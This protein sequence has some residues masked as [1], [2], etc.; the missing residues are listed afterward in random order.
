M[1]R[2]ARFNAL[3]LA[4][5]L[6]LAGT[7]AFAS[8]PELESEPEVLVLDDIVVAEALPD[9]EQ[10]LVLP[11]GRDIAIP[12]PGMEV[13]VH[14]AT[15]EGAPEIP[16]TLVTAS[17][18][19]EIGVKIGEETFGSPEG[20]A[21]LEQVDEALSVPDASLEEAEPPLQM[22]SRA[23]VAPVKCTTWDNAV[24]GYNWANRLVTWNYNPS[25]EK[26]RDSAAALQRAA[27]RWQ[28][29]LS[30]PCGN[31]GYSSLR[32]NY[33][34]TTAEAPLP[35]SGGGC[36]KFTWGSNTVGWGVIPDR[37][38]AVTCTYS[39][40]AFPYRSDQKYNTKY[41]WNTGSGTACRGN[42]YDLQGVATHEFGHTYGLDHSAGSNNQVM[43]PSAAMCE[44]SMRQLGRGD[45]R[46]ITF[47]YG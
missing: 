35:T 28:G 38:L 18:E 26:G 23:A 37:Y 47:L 8:E 5:V 1:K 16:R 45:I 27:K 13:S 10:V 11:D 39:I 30:D 44:S 4:G 9:T 7:P 12:E 25:G 32:T 43:K 14:A 40:G 20:V 31:K 42:K 46:G 34:G 33:L 3:L 24:I 22:R 6:T 29:H 15:V 36:G 19:G 21:H 41:N 2:T 17:V